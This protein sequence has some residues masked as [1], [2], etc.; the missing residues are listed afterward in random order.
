MLLA[1]EVYEIRI[2]HWALQNG[3]R[4]EDA[5]MQQIMLP[6]KFY[7]FYVEPHGPTALG[8]ETFTYQKT[9]HL[10]ST[11]SGTHWMVAVNKPQD[12]GFSS[13]PP[14]G[15]GISANPYAIR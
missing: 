9:V 10:F 11:S 3:N 7:D 13:D 5:E 1:V 2:V 6:D 8:R 14:H 15:A 4:L 12:A